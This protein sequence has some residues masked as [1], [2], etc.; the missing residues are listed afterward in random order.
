MK[1]KVII[2]EGPDGSGK[3]TLA[4][5]LAKSKYT[6]FTHN[7]V[8]PSP[9][10][11]YTSF[12]KQLELAA[13]WQGHTVIDRLHWSEKVYAKAQG[14]SCLDQRKYEELENM[15]IKLEAIVVL[16]LPSYEKCHSNW[17]QRNE[18]N[19]EYITKEEIFEKVYTG[20]NLL[21]IGQDTKLVPIKFCYND[22]DH[23]YSKLLGALMS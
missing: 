18:A 13:L 21:S 6:L 19:E 7:S 3:T 9:N 11:A 23:G 10:A 15:I 22:S 17:S 2:L 14:R 20:Y 12:K 1:R 8:Y 5:H 4:N 16:C